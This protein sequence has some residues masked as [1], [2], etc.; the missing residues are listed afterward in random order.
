MPMPPQ[1][2]GSSWFSFSG[3]IFSQEPYVI[4]VQLIR[5]FSVMAPSNGAEPY[6]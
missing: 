4:Y 3:K 6:F 5:D 2:C 1:G